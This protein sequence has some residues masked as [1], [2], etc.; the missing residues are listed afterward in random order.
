MKKLLLF[1]L[2]AGVLYGAVPVTAS[3][4]AGLVTPVKS[5]NDHRDYGVFVLPNG[6]N[7]M[8]ISDPRADKAAAS[9]SVHV[10]SASEPTDRPGLAHFLEH[11]LFMGTE[12]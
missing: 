4:G 11:M 12:K 8:L 6:M 2:I 1:S 3:T 10:G 9:L 7:V 5:P